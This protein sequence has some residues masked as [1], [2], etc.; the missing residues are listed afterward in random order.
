MLTDHP[1]RFESFL[2][3]NTETSRPK[4]EITRRLRLQSIAE[5]TV[6][7]QNAGVKIY[8]DEKPDVFRPDETVSPD[9]SISAPAFYNSREIKGLGAESVKI[10]G[11]RAVG[12]LLTETEIFVV[13]NTGGSL[14]KWNYKSEMRTKA[15][16]KTVLCRE[17]LS[18]QYGPESVRALMLGSGMEHVYRLLTST[19]G[20]KRNYFVLDGSYD[21]FPYLTHD[22]NG[23]VLLKLLCDT[24][25]T[26]QLND[27]L[28]ENLYERDPGM[29]IENDAVDGNGEPALFAYNCDM[30]RV[31]RFNAALGLHQRRGTI[32]CFDFQADAL[33]RFCGEKVKVQTIDL[34]KFER[35][36]F[37]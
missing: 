18:R 34:K 1:D 9:L 28:S 25:K 6:T 33:R 20:V 36:F 2:T 15:L 27:M 31:A 30:P 23:E 21:S 26:R 24:D 10:Q 17:R 19:G 12:A 5:T 35:R 13:Y 3:G 7:M 16:M 29:L 8:P 32:I 37:P 4:Y 14:L 22:H 11:A